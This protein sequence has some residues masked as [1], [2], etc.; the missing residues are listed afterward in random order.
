MRV[1]LQD[2]GGWLVFSDP[3]RVLQAERPEEVMPLLREAEASGLWAAGFIAYEAAP[4]FDAALPVRPPADFPLLLLGLFREPERRAAP[5]AGGAWRLTSLREPPEEDFLEAVREV[6]RRIAAG[7]TY[8]VNLTYRLAGRLEGDPAGLFLSLAGR[9]AGGCA[10]YVETERWAVCCASPELF[11]ELAEGTVTGR[12]MKGTAPRGAT[13]EEDARRAAGLRAS[14][15]ERAENVMI[16]D[17]MR[18]DIGRIARPGSVETVSL[19]DLERYP[20][21]WQMTSTVRGRTEATVSEV[22]RA[23]FPCASVTGAPKRRT[24]HII[25]ELE[26]SPRKVYTGAAGWF[27]PGGRRARFSVAIRTALVERPT[28]RL[29]FGVGGGIVWD[30]DPRREWEETRVKARVLFSAAN[31]RLLE[32]LRWSPEEGFA[33]L[34]RHLRRMERSARRFG[35]AFREAAVRA[36][37]E[38]AARGFAPRPHRVRLL[39][40][41]RGAVEV[42]AAPLEGEKKVWRVALA[43][44]PVDS[45]EIFLRHKTTRREVYEAARAEMPAGCDEVILWN[46]RGEVTEGTIANVAVRWKGRWLTPPVSCGLLPGTMREALLEEGKIEEGVVSLEMFEAAEAVAL[47]NSVRGWMEAERV[48]RPP[49]GGPSAR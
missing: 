26:T 28:G 3:V 9:Q 7:E 36:A 45:G 20:T 21:V 14:A 12:P 38:E 25:R 17:M 43:A 5:P 2:G 1:W 13:P 35:F 49:P 8:Q 46:E 11:F 23:L 47:F 19:F 42:E 10:V 33:L 40:D 22:L 27:A 31:F 41:R 24:M 44:R 32:T 6:R 30:S 29:E 15:K 18:N 4:G 37:L 39:A 48:P 16:V 34:E